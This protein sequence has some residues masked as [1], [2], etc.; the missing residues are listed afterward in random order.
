MRLSL[1]QTNNVLATLLRCF[2]STLKQLAHS[3]FS[4]VIIYFALFLLTDLLFSFYSN[5]RQTQSI[6]AIVI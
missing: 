6:A 2:L 5:V 4:L 1:M 3:V